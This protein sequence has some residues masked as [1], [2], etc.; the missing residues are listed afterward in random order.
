MKRFLGLSVVCALGALVGCDGSDD[1]VGRRASPLVKTDGLVISQVYGGGGNN[2]AVLTYD[3]V[4]LFNRGTTTVSLAGASL[5]YAGAGGTTWSKH[6]LPSTTVAPG[7][8]FLVQLGSNDETAGSP[9]PVTPDSTDMINM[10]AS[11]GKVALVTNTTS[12][13]CGSSSNRCSSQPTVVDLVGFGSS[14]TDYEGSGPAPTLSTNTVAIRRGDGCQDTGDNAADFTTGTWSAGPSGVTLHNKGSGTFACPDGDGGTTAVDDGGAPMTPADLAPPPDLATARDLATPA[15]LRAPADLAPPP[16]LAAGGG[17]SPV[18][19]SQL[20]G[21]GGNSG[22]TYR[23]D[24][25]EIFNRGSTDAD[26]GNWTIQYGSGANNFSLKAT[27][28]SGTVL[29]AGRYLLIQLAAG[30]TGT[31]LPSPDVTPTGTNAFNMSA[32]DGK[33]ALVSSQT[34]LACGTASNRCTGPTVVDLVGFG[35]ASDYEG[36][37]ATAP[38]NATRSLQRIGGGCIDTDDNRADFESQ[39]AMPRNLGTPANDCSSAAFD[40][41]V[42]RDASSVDLSGTVVDLATTGPADFAVPPDLAP[43]GPG[44]RGGGCSCDVSSSSASDG[45]PLV[46]GLGLALAALLRRRLIRRRAL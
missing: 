14:A 11:S 37:P 5:Q 28:P 19:I 2:G 23:N 42:A 32:S 3:Y 20:Y 34:L 44:R 6:N 46:V 40:L 45:S 10:G 39:P 8:Y 12:L 33:V 36:T 35:A 17:G 29:P 18:V 31:T 16:D 1:G 30:S 7:Q 43:L 24:F 15:D 13:G 21:A 27:I 22:A 9:L 38:I 25:I 26:I 41:G 4:E